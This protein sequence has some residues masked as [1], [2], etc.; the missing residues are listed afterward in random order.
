LIGMFA[1]I[2]F[3]P[4]FRHSECRYDDE[5]VKWHERF[6][7]LWRCLKSSTNG[8]MHEYALNYQP[9]WNNQ[10]HKQEQLRGLCIDFDPSD[11]RWPESSTF[12]ASS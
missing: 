11:K 3:Y 5:N 1:V 8:T 12:F 2:A 7:S 4:W 6:Q 10:K 9:S